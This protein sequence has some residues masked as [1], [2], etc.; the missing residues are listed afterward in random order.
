[1][2]GPF[3]TTSDGYVNVTDLPNVSSSYSDTQHA[4]ALENV[5]GPRELRKGGGAGWTLSD[6]RRLVLDLWYGNG[7]PAAL[8]AGLVSL[9]NQGSKRYDKVYSDLA[10]VENYGRYDRFTDDPGGAARPL[11]AVF[12]DTYQGRT[13]YDLQA[14]AAALPGDLVIGRPGGAAFPAIGAGA[15]ERVREGISAE[16]STGDEISISSGDGGVMDYL[17]NEYAPYVIGGVI[18]LALAA[19]YYWW[20]R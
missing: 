12:S 9:V 11:R 16:G 10:V 18:V 6:Y 13:V 5:L 15:L 4:S 1:M 3:V 7:D 19:I 2:P 20:V 8:V 14:A 17:D